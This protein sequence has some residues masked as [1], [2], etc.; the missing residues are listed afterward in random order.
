MTKLK[1][2]GILGAMILA[3]LTLLTSFP[4]SGKSSFLLAS[5]HRLTNACRASIDDERICRFVAGIVVIL[6]DLDPADPVPPDLAERML[7]KLRSPVRHFERVGCCDVICTPSCQLSGI[8][9]RSDGDCAGEVCVNSCP[10][11]CQNPC[12]DAAD[13]C[14]QCV[15]A[16]SAIEARLATNSVAQSLADTMDDACN[17]LVDPTLVQQC[18]DQIGQLVPVRLDRLLA[19][20]PPLIVCRSR[21]FHSCPP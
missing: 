2:A 16:V 20:F 6:D 18:A 7:R 9:C 14:D 13:K 1:G 5:A 15:T 8:P 19:D 4:A 17:P 12:D 21:T 10:Q 11:T 3:A